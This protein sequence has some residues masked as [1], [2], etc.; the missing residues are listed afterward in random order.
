MLGTA[1]ALS[2]DG[3]L[4]VSAPGFSAG[5]LYSGTQAAQETY[6]PESKRNP[7]S[8]D[9]DGALIG[10]QLPGLSNGLYAVDIT[11]G[12][13]SSFT[14]ITTDK[15]PTTAQSTYMQNLKALQTDNIVGATVYNNQA[16]QSEAIGAVYLYT[17][18]SSGIT[19]PAATIYGPHSWNVLGASGF[20]SSL[21][22]IDLNNTNTSQLAIGADATGGSGAVYVIDKE[23]VQSD[24]IDLAASLG[25]NQYLAHAVASLTLY[26]AESQDLFGSGIVNLGDVNQDGYD[27]LL[28]QAMNAAS[29]A[30]AGYVL[31][32]S[33][34]FDS[35]IKGNPATGSVAS[36]SIGLFSSADGTSFS[37]A[38]LQQL[39]YG[40][41]FT[42]SG[43]YGTGDLDANGINDIQLGSGPNGSAYLTWGHPYLEAV[44]NLA[45][46]KLASNTGYLLDGL[47]TSTADSLRSIG[48]FNGDGYGDFISIEPG[49]FVN[50]VRIELGA[51]TQAILAD[52][53]YNDYS[54]TVS[55]DTQVLPAGDINGDGLADLAL[56]LNQNVS[57]AADGNQ[58]GG[59]TT[60]IVYGRNS[61]QLPIG[62]AFGLLA[63]VD[64]ATNAPLTS[65]PSQQIAGGLSSASPAV[66]AVGETLY[67]AVQGVGD[68][69]TSIWFTSSSDGGS[70][71]SSW[72]N[73]SESNPTFAT[74]AAPSL[75]FFEQKLYMSFLN[76]DGELQLASLN[77][78]SPSL[79]DW[80]TLPPSPAAM[81]P[82]P[83][84]PVT[85]PR[86]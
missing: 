24:A 44:N 3:T 83:P 31:F 50:N 17:N 9:G 56:F 19:T 68:S 16:V 62:S 70:S 1:I 32:G 55:A 86:S 71:W 58:G 48:D 59:S 85:T 72:S 60:G 47:A 25:G 38:I 57:S 39:G 18:A 49:T 30:G 45:L 5:L 15:S 74:T 4:A 22:F 11:N 75:A 21:A 76:P 79:S 34:Q 82:P 33:D 80:S 8:P 65:L 77:P 28:I 52:Y 40:S 64:P 2:S 29:A 37:S 81:T 63:P 73:L 66:I 26:G 20:G 46:N 42:G 13:N 78:E 10:V 27:D 43:S 23:Q 14:A 41:G 51:N 61:E 84:S 7:S 53:L 67:A 35:K 69:D 54:F 36:G 6:S 12:T